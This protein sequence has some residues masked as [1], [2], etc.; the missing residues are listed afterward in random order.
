M[1][2]SRLLLP[3]LI[4]IC[5]LFVA[6]R[7]VNPAKTAFQLNMRAQAESAPGD[8]QWQVENIRENWK[9]EETAIIICDM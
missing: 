3:A 1:K 6:C 4:G 7:P 8:G 2:P 5:L 9:P